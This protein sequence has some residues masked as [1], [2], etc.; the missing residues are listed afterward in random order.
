MTFVLAFLFALSG[1]YIPGP[2]DG[3]L[4]GRCSDEEPACEAGLTCTPGVSAN[5]WSAICTAECENDAECEALNV[6]GRC[7]DFVCWDG[8]CD[9]VMCK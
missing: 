5:G 1:C 9:A 4:A 7:G 2:G 8:H 3:E 6:H